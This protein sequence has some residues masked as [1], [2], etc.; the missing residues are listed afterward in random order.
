MKLRKIHSEET[1]VLYQQGCRKAFLK[2]IF[3]FTGVF[4]QRMDDGS[5]RDL[6]KDLSEELE[7]YYQLKLKVKK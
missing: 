2:R 5:Y 6:N 4:W 1:F 3:A 7:N